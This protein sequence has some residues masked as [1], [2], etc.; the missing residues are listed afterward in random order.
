MAIYIFM[1]KN[2]NNVMLANMFYNIKYLNSVYTK[3][4]MELCAS[5]C[6]NILLCEIPNYYMDML[7]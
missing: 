3:E 7:K 5:N 2:K 6:P 1:C 4:Q